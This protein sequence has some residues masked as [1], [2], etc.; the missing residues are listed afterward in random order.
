MIY[1]ITSTL[2]LCLGIFTYNANAQM[3]LIASAHT[4]YDGAKYVTKD[5]AYHY[6]SGTK[7]AN[8]NKYPDVR[9]YD[10]MQDSTV[11]YEEVSGTMTPK[12]K[13]IYTYT[14][15]DIDEAVHME[16]DGSKWENDFKAIFSYAG[17]KPDTIFYSSWRSSSQ[18]WRNPR[19]YY[20]YTWTGANVA[21]ERRRA[22]S[23]SASAWRWDWEKRYMWSGSNKTDSVF[24]DWNGGSSGSFVDE[25]RRAWTYTGGKVTA[26]EDYDWN[27][28]SW[29]FKTRRAFIYD[30]QSRIDSVIEDI[31]SSGWVKN[32]K[33][34]Y[35]YNSGSATAKPDSVIRTVWDQVSGFWVNRER[36]YLDHNTEGKRTKQYAESWDGKTPGSW[37]VTFNDSNKR[38]HYGWPQSISE[39]EATTDYISVYPT[40]A[41]DVINIAIN[42]VSNGEAVQFAITDMS[43]RIIRE[44]KARAQNVT[45]ISVADL[46]AGNYLMSMG[47]GRDISTKKFVISR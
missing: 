37:V 15:T 35:I 5:S 27:G 47:Y 18:T 11:I 6:H 29:D 41:N 9:E 31:N 43:G 36:M 23:N 42:T 3:R 45:T 19:S 16:W 33:W 7:G 28:S 26:E 10:L 44:W 4:E 21:S 32:T 38:W 12:E 14:G 24:A 46:P 39:K 30:A 13:I 17:G 22:W 25:K 2:L 1:K 8:G 20:V 34:Q 40:P